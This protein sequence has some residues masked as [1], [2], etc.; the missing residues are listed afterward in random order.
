MRTIQIKGQSEVLTFEPYNTYIYVST[1]PYIILRL[2]PCKQSE[3]I[4]L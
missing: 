3:Q 4:E 1:Y 2:K